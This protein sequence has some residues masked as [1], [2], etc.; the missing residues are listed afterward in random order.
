MNIPRIKTNFRISILLRLFIFINVFIIRKAK[1]AN[2]Q[3]CIT[4][5][6]KIFRRISIHGFSSIFFSSTEGIEDTTKIS[7]IQRKLSR[8]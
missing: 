3:K 7:T 5:S 1:I 2:S 6:V 8:R 4:G